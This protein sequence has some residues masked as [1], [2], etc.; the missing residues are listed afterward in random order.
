LKAIGA[1][2]IEE[3]APP[4]ASITIPPLGF[5]DKVDT[6]K[7]VGPGVGVKALSHNGWSGFAKSPEKS[8]DI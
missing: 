3:G 5:T 2:L 4:V 8:N 7:L 6:A 1:A